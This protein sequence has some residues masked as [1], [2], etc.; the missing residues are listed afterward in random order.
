MKR[1]KKQEQETYIIPQN[2]SSFFSISNIVKPRNVAEAVVITIILYRVISAVPFVFELKAA[3]TGTSCIICFLV[4]FIGVKEESVLSFLQA[5]FYYK[6][7]SGLRRIRIPDGKV[8]EGSE[9][10]GRVMESRYDKLVR[11]LKQGRK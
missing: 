4:F 1:E 6:I 3:I 9:V 8:R 2:Y 5:Y 10:E 11:K 7:T